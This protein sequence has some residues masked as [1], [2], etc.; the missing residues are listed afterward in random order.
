MWGFWEKNEAK[1][2]QSKVCKECKCLFA[3]SEGRY[4]YDYCSLE[5]CRK[6]R[7]EREELERRE[8]D[9][10][11]YVKAHWR[12]F[13]K[14]VKRKKEAKRKADEKMRKDHPYHLM[15][16]GLSQLYGQ[17]GQSYYLLRNQGLGGGNQYARS[18]SWFA[19]GM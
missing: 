15:A 16:P 3:Y 2:P 8:Q 11:V 14:Q 18:S 1:G 12:D 7:M 9:V 6:Q 13:E 4:N 10:V 19:A 17:Q 5:A